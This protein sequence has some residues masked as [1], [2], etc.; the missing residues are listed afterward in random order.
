MNDPTTPRTISYG[1]FDPFRPSSSKCLWQEGQKGFENKTSA[2][3]SGQ[4]KNFVFRKIKSPP[5]HHTPLEYR[6]HWFYQ[7]ALLA[8]QRRQ[9]FCLLFSSSGTSHPL[10]TV[11][12]RTG[13]EEYSYYPKKCRKNRV[14]FHGVIVAAPHASAKEENPP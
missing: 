1:T 14:F 10:A 12:Y 7:Q 2:L 13:D 5:A 6:R 3:H 4:R 9:S 8:S 11:D